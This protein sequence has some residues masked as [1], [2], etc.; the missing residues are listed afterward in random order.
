M[1]P[2]RT[3]LS[4]KARALGLLAMR[5]QSRHEL[6]RKLGAHA[7]TAEE[8]EAVLNELERAGHL[9]Q[10]RFGESLLRRREQ[11]YGRL[12]IARELDE[13]RVDDSLRSSLLGELADSERERAFGVWEKRFGRAPEDLKERARQYRFLAQRGFDGETISSVLKRAGGASSDDD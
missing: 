7:E 9:S 12:R 8:V 1:N 5:E 6:A 4:L 10:R 13:H 3:G 2:G 11:R